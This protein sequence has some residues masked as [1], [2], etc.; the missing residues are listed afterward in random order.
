MEARLQAEEEQRAAIGVDLHDGVGQMLAYLNLYLSLMREKEKIEITDII[1]VQDK[2]NLIV[3][4]S[5]CPITEITS[6]SSK[7]LS[8]SRNSLSSILFPL[9]AGSSFLSKRKS[10]KFPYFNPS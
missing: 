6:S 5:E 8:A 7:I 10:N 4:V 9:N 1:K 2:L 3:G